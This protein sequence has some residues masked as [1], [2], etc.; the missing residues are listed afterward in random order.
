M[1]RSIII[2]ASS[3]NFP[4]ADLRKH[5][6]VRSMIDGRGHIGGFCACWCRN[7]DHRSSICVATMLGARHGKLDNLPLDRRD[8]SE[9]SRPKSPRATI[10]ASERRWLPVLDSRWL[11]QL[12]YAGTPGD[13]RT[14]L[15][16][17]FGR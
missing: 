12:R 14:D 1:M 4:D 15:F 13:D 10:T 9:P 3:G 8:C 16:D 5:H 2:T 7:L 6:C 17:I 11:F